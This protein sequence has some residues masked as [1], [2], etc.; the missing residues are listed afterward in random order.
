M[1]D[2]KAIYH[3]PFAPGKIPVWPDFQPS[4]MKIV[5]ERLG[6][7]GDGPLFGQIAFH[8]NPKS[9]GHFARTKG[10]R[11]EEGAIFP[12]FPAVCIQQE[13]MHIHAESSSGHLWLTVQYPSLVLV[14][15]HH[16]GICLKASSRTYV[17]S[18]QR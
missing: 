10:P 15:A 5:N 2:E 9:D 1:N 16:A 13:N 18:R 17:E 6:N 14:G 4:A 7:K 11:G 8:H 3:I 12:V